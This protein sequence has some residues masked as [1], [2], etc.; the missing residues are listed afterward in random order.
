MNV[1]VNLNPTVGPWTLNCTV[2]IMPQWLTINAPDPREPDGIR[3]TK[4]NG[5]PVCFVQMF[6]TFKVKGGWQ[7]ELGGQL[8]SKGY[9]E[10]IL[11]T[12]VYFDL[13]AAIQRSLLKDGSLVLRLEGRDLA[14]LSHYNIYTD[15]GSH[16]IRQTNYMDSQ[17]IKFSLR[18]NFNT[19]QSKYR[20]TGAGADEKARM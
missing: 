10:N 19:A 3:K 20:G 12:N 18:Y 2:G 8:N 1:N 14:G 17:R 4:F 13:T 5:K 9:T 7:F 6:N 16:T 15:F 11:L